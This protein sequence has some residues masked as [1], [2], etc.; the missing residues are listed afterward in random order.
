MNQKET[1]QNNPPQCKHFQCP[2]PAMQMIGGYSPF[3]HRHNPE[4]KEEWEFCGVYGC[5]SWV[6]SNNNDPNFCTN[7]V[8]SELY[9]GGKHES[10]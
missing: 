2:D 10:K 3:C 5:S 1:S 7:H 4:H 9:L 8:R 6:V